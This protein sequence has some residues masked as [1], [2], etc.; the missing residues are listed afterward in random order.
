MYLRM[1]EGINVNLSE[2]LYKV[3]SHQTPRVTL[4]SHTAVFTSLKEMLQVDRWGK[5]KL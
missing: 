3:A 5:V 1:T 2:H 4:V